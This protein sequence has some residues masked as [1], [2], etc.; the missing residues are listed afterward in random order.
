MRAAQVTVRVGKPRLNRTHRRTGLGKRS[1]W[2]GRR[3]SLCRRRVGDVV[4]GPCRE[5]TVARA[6]R[7]HSRIGPAPGGQRAPWAPNAR[8]RS[9]RHRPPSPGARSRRRGTPA[10][11]TQA[12]IDCTGA[13][14]ATRW[15]CTSGQ[16]HGPSAIRS[17]PVRGPDLGPSLRHAP[18]NRWARAR[19]R[20]WQ[21]KP[22]TRHPGL[23]PS[24]ARRGRHS[25]AR[26]G[27]ARPRRIRMRRRPRP[28][29]RPDRRSARAGSWR[30]AQRRLACRRCP[31]RSA[32]VVVRDCAGMYAAA[33][34]RG[35]R[36][37]RHA[38]GL[39]RRLHLRAPRSPPH[40]RSWPMACMK[41]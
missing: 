22:A 35:P 11:G 20:G 8:C 41:A 36:A 39:A 23:A 3:Q 33:H 30:S 14:V 32:G 17:P 38:E 21:M 25:A 1:G 16:R 13:P 4:V 34:R 27:S 37:F 12:G 28:R 6:G 5:I 15:A 18:P 24:Q 29:A 26:P 40:G 9:S 2:A 7:C 19:D 31:A 10:H